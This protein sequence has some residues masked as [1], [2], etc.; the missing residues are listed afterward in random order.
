MPAPDYAAEIAA[1]TAAA[2][3]GE[4]TIETNDERVTYRSMSDL[5]SALAF[6]KGEARMSGPAGRRSNSTLAA[7]E[8]D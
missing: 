7:F 5:L 4:L 1:L 6:F 8:S 3:S 2:A